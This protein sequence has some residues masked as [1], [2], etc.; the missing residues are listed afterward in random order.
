MEQSES[1]SSSHYGE[2]VHLAGRELAAF[3]AAVGAMF[4]PEQAKLS[5]QDWLDELELLD[6]PPRSTVRDWR[7]ITIGAS[8]RLAVRL[9][10]AFDPH[11]LIGTSTT[12]A[13]VS[14]I[15]SSNRLALTPVVSCARAAYPKESRMRATEQSKGKENVSRN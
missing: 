6:G 2:Q 12:D 3:I 8:V 5:A 9:N 4:G 15:P 7:D 14:P 1:V 10:V 13:K 11:V